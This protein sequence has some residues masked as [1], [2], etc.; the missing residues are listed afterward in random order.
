[1]TPAIILVRGLSFH[2]EPSLVEAVDSLRFAVG[3][4]G[5]ESISQVGSYP[6]SIGVDSD[7]DADLILELVNRQ[8]DK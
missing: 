5:K 7:A 2:D 8:D 3:D 6:I 4:Q 1:M